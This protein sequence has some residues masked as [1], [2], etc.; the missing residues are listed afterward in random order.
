MHFMTANSMMRTE[1][2]VPHGVQSKL[3]APHGGRP[4]SM[5]QV[6]KE[7]CR[8]WRSDRPGWWSNR[9]PLYGGRS[10][11]LG[12]RLDRHPL[13]RTWSDHLDAWSDHQPRPAVESP[14]EH[15][16]PVVVRVWESHQ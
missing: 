13:F 12:S 2:R 1:S 7:R 14:V 9:Q 15:E 16:A 8:S 3:W 11:R 6:M 5:K 4:K 10:D